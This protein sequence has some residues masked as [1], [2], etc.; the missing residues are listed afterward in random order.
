MIEIESDDAE[1]YTPIKRTFAHCWARASLAR[2]PEGQVFHT[3][4]VDVYG[5]GDAATE[6][7]TAIS[8]GEFVLDERGEL[9]FRS[10]T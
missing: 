9:T 5:D 3:M 1:P 2:D 10:R 6:I 8:K 4:T 7:A